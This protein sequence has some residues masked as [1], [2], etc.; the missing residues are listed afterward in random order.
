MSP[1]EFRVFWLHHRTAT[2]QYGLTC[3]SQGI[4]NDRRQGDRSGTVRGYSIYQISLHWLIAALVFVQLVFGES[5]AEFVEAEEGEPVSAQDGWLAGVHYYFGIAILALVAVRLALRLVNGAPPPPET[6]G[7][8]ELLGKVA[9]LGR[10]T[11]FMSQSR[12]RDCSAIISAIR[13][14]KSMLG[15]SPSSLASSSCMSP[16]HSTTSSGARTVF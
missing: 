14:A 13:M 5:M 9:H 2:L 6:N 15:Q 4:R 7:A 10:S 12:S 3:G 8:L 11:F 16:L 1:V